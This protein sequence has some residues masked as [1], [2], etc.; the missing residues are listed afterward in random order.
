M[1]NEAEVADDIEATRVLGMGPRAVRAWHRPAFRSAS[2]DDDPVFIL[3]LR[4]IISAQP[5]APSAGRRNPLQKSRE[6]ML[7]LGTQSLN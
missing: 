7:T 6:G 2:D 4:L 3:R 5:S 1:K